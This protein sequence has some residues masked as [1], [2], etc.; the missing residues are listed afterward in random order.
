MTI[1]INLFFQGVQMPSKLATM[2]VL[3]K[4]S[5]QLEDAGYLKHSN[6]IDQIL[7]KLA[8]EANLKPLGSVYQDQGKYYRKYEDLTKGTIVTREV[9]PEGQIIG[10]SLPPSTK[11]S[12][13]EPMPESN[14][15]LTKK[16]K[17]DDSSS[18]T[19]GIYTMFNDIASAIGGDPQPTP[20]SP[21]QS[22]PAK[23][24]KSPKSHHGK[25][26]I[27]EKYLKQ[28]QNLQHKLKELGIDLDEEPTKV[29]L[30][31]SPTTLIDEPTM[32]GGFSFSDEIIPEEPELDPDQEATVLMQM[33]QD[34]TLENDKT[35]KSRP[36]KPTRPL[37]S[38]DI[39]P[40]DDDDVSEWL[41]RVS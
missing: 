4:L 36:S 27:A 14:V 22:N 38:R 17:S 12:I 40:D 13:K 25:S 19:D 11:S 21:S 10:T 29:F 2:K 39:I 3:S 1:N 8:Q 35:I 24:S 33:P 34:A 5:N 26:D 16:P 32:R 15:D 28:L 18:W 20:T 30:R 37:A 6:Y 31:A 41:E 7:T 23:D 9:T